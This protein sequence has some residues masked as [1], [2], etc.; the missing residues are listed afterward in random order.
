[1]DHVPG[2]ARVVLCTVPDVARGKEL[3]RALVERRLVACVNVLGGATSIYRWRGAVE[4]ASEALLVMKTD[5]RRLLEL[6]AALRELHPYE[7]PELIALEAAHVE[8]RY[9]HW[10]LEETADDAGG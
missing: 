2:R 4:E 1:M 5:A 8:R 7:V 6:E 9:L 3:A 10:L